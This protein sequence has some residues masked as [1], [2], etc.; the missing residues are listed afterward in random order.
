MYQ[1]G[2]LTLAVLIMLACSVFPY[3][4]QMTP[5]K[6]QLVRAFCIFTT[7]LVNGDLH[8]LLPA[9]ISLLERLGEV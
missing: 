7:S 9:L 3:E 5:I 1:S 4:T 2:V 6:K 8:A